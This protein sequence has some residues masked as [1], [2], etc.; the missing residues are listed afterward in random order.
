M[1]QPGENSEEQA[2]MSR[3]FVDGH[4][5][6]GN[7][8]TLVGMV[9]GSVFVWSETRSAVAGAGVAIQTVAE[10]ATRSEARL[11]QHAE[12]IRLLETE[13]ASKGAVLDLILVELTDLN[14]EIR[15]LSVA[16]R[17]GEGQ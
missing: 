11:D 17:D 3:P 1:S 9:A 12:R 10:R 13:Q 4:I 15:A 5:S 14:A 16:R 8:L 7:V 2:S 6:L